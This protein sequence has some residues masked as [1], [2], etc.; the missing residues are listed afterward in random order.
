MTMPVTLTARI[1]E[2]RHILLKFH[3]LELPPPGMETQGVAAHP[4]GEGTLLR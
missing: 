4:P 2:E 3:D 1:K